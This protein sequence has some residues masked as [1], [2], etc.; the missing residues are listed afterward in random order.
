MVAVTDKPGIREL[1][2]RSVKAMALWVM[3]VV[4]VAWPASE[5]ALHLAFAAFVLAAGALFLSLVNL[6]VLQSYD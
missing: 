6:V 5:S 1:T 3:I 2:K 4:A